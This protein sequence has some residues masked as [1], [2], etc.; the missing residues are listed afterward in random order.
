MNVDRYKIGAA[1]VMLSRLKHKQLNSNR[2]NN[3]NIGRWLI[4]AGIVF[5]LSASLI[6]GLADFLGGRIADKKASQGVVIIAERDGIKIMRV[7]DRASGKWI[8]FTNTG[9]VMR[10]RSG[11]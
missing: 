9:D 1:R 7:F 4:K 6:G 3:D 11:Y 5:I 8:H 2:M 10:E